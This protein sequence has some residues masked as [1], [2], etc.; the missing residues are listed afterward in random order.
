[1]RIRGRRW[2]GMRFSRGEVEEDF[3]RTSLPQDVAEGDEILDGISG[4]SVRADGGGECGL[5]SMGEPHDR[6]ITLGA[7]EVSDDGDSVSY[8]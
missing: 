7:A 1:M 5:N 2:L 4:G 6:R 3:G 8:G